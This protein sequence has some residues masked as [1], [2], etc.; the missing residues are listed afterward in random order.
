M[1]GHIRRRARNSW[2]VVVDF[3]RDP[4]TGKR[5]QLWR[6]VQG[7]KRD[8]EALLAELLYQQQQGIES[9][10][11][12]LTVAEYL[13]RWLESY[14]AQNTAPT[15]RNRY[16]QL[17]RLYIVPVIGHLALAKLRPL[18]I[19]Q[20][21]ASMLERGLA[22]RTALQAHRVLREALKH[23]VR[24]QLLTRNPADAVEPPRAERYEAPVLTPQDV[25]R[26][27]RA[28]DDTP[29]GALIHVAVYTGLRLGELLGLRWQDV[30]PDRAVL[31]V[32][33]TCQWLPREG[34]RFA[35]PKSYR[36]TRPVALAP[37]TFDRLRQHRLRQMEERLA[38]GPGYHDYDLVFGELNR[39]T[40]HAINPPCVVEAS[41]AQHG[42]VNQGTRPSARPRL[43]LARSGH[44]PEGRVG[45]TRAQ[46][47][48]HYAGSVQPHAAPP[49]G[50][51]GDGFRRLVSKR[52]AIVKAHDP[53]IV[54]FCI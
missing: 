12:R 40:S 31:H 49:A 16:E 44:A 14:A 27:M 24:W 13:G 39:A 47:D 21:Y 51:G 37:E 2:T 25:R 43:L 46:P 42:F 5:R 38:V 4:R 29:F 11:G 23:A 19:Q 7:T 6:S 52:L 32:R 10:P 9:L 54:I 15:T 48:Q 1:R 17:I 35:P 50:G 3:G 33:Q 36:S 28:A 34:F 41:P 18:Q 8:A 53:Q 26:V 22:K 45:A 20:V 30:I